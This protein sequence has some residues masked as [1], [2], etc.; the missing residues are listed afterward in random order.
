M[1]LTVENKS[2]FEVDAYA[3]VVPT[4]AQGLMSQGHGKEIKLRGGIEIEE[5]IIDI[6][7]LAIGSAAITTC[8]KLTN[9]KCLIHVP[10]RLQD[11]QLAKIEHIR[12]SIRAAL[13]A[14]KI[15][16]IESIIIP[17][18]GPCA[19]HIDVK[20]IG[21]A[22][23]DEIRNFKETPPNYIRIV[24]PNKE[25]TTELQQFAYPQK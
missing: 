16:K 11:K 7:P 20:E 2:I 13:V 25:L 15:K 5:E 12:H 19:Q 9:V 22:I 23:I 17:G 4:S 8:G 1:D 14:A 21:R 24:D 3:L 18:P 10:N 6:A